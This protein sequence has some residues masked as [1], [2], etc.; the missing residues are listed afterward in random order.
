MFTGLVAKLGFCPNSGFW[1]SLGGGNCPPP[2]PTIS[3]AY[4]LTTCTWPHAQHG[5]WS[6]DLV[7]EVPFKIILSNTYKIIEPHWCHIKNYKW[8]EERMDYIKTSQKRFQN[9]IFLFNTEVKLDYIV[10]CCFNC[11]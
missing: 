7:I 10:E 9:L 3:Y 6:S 5:S 4:D 1:L 11:N 2:C 8:R